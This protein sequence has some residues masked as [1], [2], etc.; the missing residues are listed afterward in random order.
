M[1]YTKTMKPMTINKRITIAIFSFLVA[2]LFMVGLS[3]YFLLN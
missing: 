3:I 2:A 1:E